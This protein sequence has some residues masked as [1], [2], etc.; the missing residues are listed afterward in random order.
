MQIKTNPD[1]ATENIL[2][3]KASVNRS[4]IQFQMLLFVSLPCS[5]LC[6]SAFPYSSIIWSAF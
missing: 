4:V 2:K 5:Q 1:N 6:A 3:Y